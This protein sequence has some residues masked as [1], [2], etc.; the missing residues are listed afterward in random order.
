MEYYEKLI[1]AL[2]EYFKRRL[3]LA[4]G[5]AELRDPGFSYHDQQDRGTLCGMV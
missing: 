1:R 2:E 3:L 4:G 5:Y